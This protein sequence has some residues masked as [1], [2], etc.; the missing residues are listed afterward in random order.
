MTRQFIRCNYTVNITKK[1]IRRANL[2]IK[3]EQAD[4][5]HISIPYQMSYAAALQI[6]EQPR[7]LNWLENY[8]KKS[9][10]HLSCKKDWYEELCQSI[11]STNTYKLVENNIYLCQIIKKTRENYSFPFAS[12][13]VLQA[14]VCGK[15][16]SDR[17]DAE[18]TQ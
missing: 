13:S 3:P 17:L 9:D 5:I 4:T 12:I 2:R 6:L 11:Y 1:N 10:R 14:C 8:E 18:R 16:S 7:I 15:R